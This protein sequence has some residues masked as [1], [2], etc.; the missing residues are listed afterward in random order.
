MT[1]LYWL[2]IIKNVRDELRQA[3]TL[4]DGLGAATRLAQFQLDFIQTS[5]LDRVIQKKAASQAI[6]PEFRRVRLAILGSSTTAHLA[7]GVRIAGL[8]RKMWID[9]YDGEYGQYWQELIN[10]NSGLHDFE[11]TAILFI[12]DGWHIAAE[13][14]GRMSGVEVAS[15]SAALKERIKSCWEIATK[16]FG[17]KVLQQ[18]PIA[19]QPRLIG[20][21]EH[22]LP[23]SRA[24]YIM[25]FNSELRVLADEHGVDVLAID[26]WAMRDG[27]DQWYDPALWLRSKQ[28]ISPVAVPLFGD[29]VARILTAE[30][31]QSSKCLVLDLDNTL[32][33]GVIGDDGLQGIVLGPG[34]AL[35]E[36]FV[37][38]QEVCRELARRGVILAV[39][40]KN[41]ENNALEPFDKHPEMVLKRSDISCFVANW[42]DK[43]S[44]L[45]RIASELNIGLDSL[46]FVDDNPFERELVRHALPM[47]AV[48][49][50]PADPACFA[51]TLSD[52]GYFEAVTITEEDLQRTTKYGE[53]Q[54]REKLKSSSASFEEYLQN[55]EMKLTWRRFDTIGL[56]RIVQLINKTNQFNCTTRRYTEEEVRRIM[57][58]QCSIGLQLR[59]IDKL[60]DNG[61][62]AIVIGKLGDDG[63]FLI[64]TWLMSCR[65]IGRQVEQAT[66]NIIVWQAEQLGARHLI[67]EYL[68]TAKNKMVAD[69]FEKLGFVPIGGSPT[70]AMRYKL[71]LNSFSPINTV[72][73]IEE[74]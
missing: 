11:P 71:E 22:R 1:G 27:L 2:P 53:N 8:R 72:I 70:T 13:I 29:L 26:W 16:K 52:A 69:H 49:E 39:C 33:G 74:V 67:G 45:R 54:S 32:W 57:S 30:Q 7:P 10:P 66:L 5:T 6:D 19:I 24:Q 18:T 34:S 43:A 20:N 62:I 64:D 68:R 47:V 44:N 58:D 38:F 21:N 63:E 36:A 25:R 17:A 15:K 65:V 73:D 59:L 40:S 41:D 28:E 46:V 42:E 3:A 31:G 61:I 23:G 60:G 14:D 51:S 12:L 35:G 55:L 37:A 4:D 56:Q 9:V 50:L 48:P